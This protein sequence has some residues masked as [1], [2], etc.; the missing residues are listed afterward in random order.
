MSDSVTAL[1][2][3]WP[4]WQQRILKYAEMEAKNCPVVQKLLGSVDAFHERRDQHGML[5]DY[6]I[7]LFIL[8]C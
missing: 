5:L 2:E 8:Q 6:G 7:Y 4:A 3:S 1:L